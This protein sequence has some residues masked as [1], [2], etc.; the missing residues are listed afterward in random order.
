MHPP[1][2]TPPPSQCQ[3]A[4]LLVTI[5]PMRHT[6]F[7]S[8]AF[9]L[10]PPFFPFDLHS[11]KRS[12]YFD[13][14]IRYLIQL[15]WFCPLTPFLLLPPSFFFS[16]PPPPPFGLSSLLCLNIS[17]LT[18]DAHRNSTPHSVLTCIF[19]VCC[20]SRLY[21]LSPPVSFSFF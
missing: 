20:G 2:K 6:H 5:S 21:R 19:L 18:P 10:P 8:A 16:P 15:V 13:F 9:L 17:P 11:R 3:T 12:L 7:N 4:L 1:N 14:Y